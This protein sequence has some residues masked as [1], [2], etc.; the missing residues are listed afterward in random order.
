MAANDASYI[1]YETFLSP[2]FSASSFANTLIQSTNN[3]SDTS[4]D[5][6]TP[7]SRTLFD[8]QEVDTHIHS[9]TTTSALPLLSHTASQTEAASRILAALSTQVSTLTASYSRL[10]SEVIA[11]H[12]AAEEVRLAASRLWVTIKIGRAVQRALQLGRQL[13]LQMADVRLSLTAPRT[14]DDHRSMRSAAAT[15]LTLKAL[16]AADGPGEEGEHLGRI[17][18]VNTLRRDLVESSE[19][20][21]RG[22]AQQ[23]VREFAL[24]SVPG[25][26]QAASASGT[27]GRDARS[28]SPARGTMAAA[29]T[30]AAVAPSTYAQTSETKARTTSAL[31][32]LYLLSP[33]PA[34]NS[35][36][37]FTPTLLLTALQT[38]LHTSL[39]SS[40]ASLSRALAQLPTLPRALQEV[41]ARCKN[42]VA[43]EVLL[44]SIEIPE[45]PLVAVSTTKAHANGTNGDVEGKSNG[46]ADHADGE[47]GP[48]KYLLDPLLSAL[49]TGSMPSFFWR[50]LASGMGSKVGDILNRGGAPART[51]RTQRDS[52]RERIREA[53]LRSCE[54]ARLPEGRAGDNAWEREAAVMVAS[55][56]GPL[57]R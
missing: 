17:A 48:K 10:D 1:D 24:A 12:A 23:I 35:Q 52:V 51:L 42:V 41:T 33:V 32:T 56:V 31:I 29:T 9:L 2:S 36:R 53:V 50:S 21:L 40:A 19:Q 45:H 18:V 38:Y 49:D 22:K 13:E 11:R 7:L 4:L 25:Q 14:R 55:V 43:L 39:T 26:S 5:L 3:A 57:S 44:Q 46:V 34:G 30:T 15:I 20:R 6:S 16:F 54:G 37:E 8:L 28:P 47:D 27:A